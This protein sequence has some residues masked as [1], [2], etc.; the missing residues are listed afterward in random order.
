MAKRKKALDELREDLPTVVDIGPKQPSPYRE[1][2]SLD[3]A[4]RIADYYGQG[5]TLTWIAAQSGMP[6]YGTLIK[7]SK[8]HAE[9]SRM[10]RGVREARALHYENSAI[11]TAENACGKDAD[12]LKFEAYKWG[13]EVNDPGTYGKKVTHAGDQTNPVV[14]KVVTGFGEPN[15]WQQEPK[16]K[17]DGTIE[18][19][20]DGKEGQIEEQATPKSEPTLG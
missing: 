4:K 14:L 16:L 2:Y 9:L 18:V 20:A 15:S 12:R 7:W 13:A 3:L 17:A 11:E 19:E 1:M 6:A 10:L 8:E 5:K